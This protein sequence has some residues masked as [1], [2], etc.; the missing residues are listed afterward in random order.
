LRVVW[1]GKDSNTNPFSLGKSITFTEICVSWLPNGSNVGLF[2]VAVIWFMKYSINN[3]NSS[4]V[5][6]LDLLLLLYCCDRNINNF[7]NACKGSYIKRIDSHET[8]EFS[9]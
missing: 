8:H 4:L 2:F 3:K 1:G 9:A 6:H 7:Q 5:I